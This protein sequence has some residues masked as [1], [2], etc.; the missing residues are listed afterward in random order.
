MRPAQKFNLILF[1]SG[2]CSPLAIRR[3]IDRTNQHQ[4]GK[5]QDPA[6]KRVD[7]QLKRIAPQ[8]SQIRRHLH[9]RPELSGQEFATTAYLSKRLTAAQIP[10]QV[11]PGK[12]G[13]ITD[14]VKSPDARAPV[15]AIRA[16]IDALP[17]Q[18]EN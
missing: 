2:R 17:I 14:I 12:R 13:I 1:D 7:A 5:E 3:V 15:V 16:D 6:L 10:H 11:A 18:E 9:E 4:S 8:L